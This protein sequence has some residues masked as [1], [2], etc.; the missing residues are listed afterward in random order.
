MVQRSAALVG[1]GFL[2]GRSGR[3]WGR[4]SELMP[5]HTT[6]AVAQIAASCKRVMAVDIPV[7]FNA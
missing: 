7:W 4:V 2:T 1:V 3:G 5:V 6:R